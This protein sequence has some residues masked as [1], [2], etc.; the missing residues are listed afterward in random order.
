MSMI[1]ASNYVCATTLENLVL[2]KGA[3][4]PVLDQS[5]NMLAE[6]ERRCGTDVAMLFA[7]PTVKS[8]P[9]STV[10][11]WYAGADGSPRPLADFD[12]IGRRPFAEILRARLARLLPIMAD[13]TIGATVGAA[14]NIRSFQ[15]IYVVGRDAVIVN[16]GMLPRD[17]ASSET[18]REAHFRSTLGS[19]APSGFPTPPFDFK[20]A[21]AFTDAIT[22]QFQA[23]GARETAEARDA[24]QAAAAAQARKAASGPSAPVLRPMATKKHRPWI[25]PLVASVLAAAV[26]VALLMPGV[27][28]NATIISPDQ[29]VIDQQRRLVQDVNRSL[30]QQI[31][32]LKS[33]S[34]E[35]V[36]RAL[37]GA[38]NAA[39]APPNLLPPPAQS[40]R[41]PAS[42]P[43]GP[44][45]AAELADQA[46][47]LV[48]A[49]FGDAGATGSAFFISDQLLV[50]TDHVVSGPGGRDAATVTIENEAL[51]K[52][53]AAKVL[54]RTHVSRPGGADF[55]LLETPANTSRAFLRLAGQPERASSVRSIDFSG[56]VA[57][58]AVIPESVMTDGIV[59]SLIDLN[60]QNVIVNSAATAR[61]SSGGPLMDLCSRAVGVNTLLSIDS[62]AS[63]GFSLAQPTA[64][65]LDFLKANGKNIA[66][67]TTACVPGGI[68]FGGPAATSPASSPASVPGSPPRPRG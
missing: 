14:L 64:A 39:L 7:Q 18:A 52:P 32:E 17:V 48:R 9:G 19:F 25:A 51:G 55:A 34:A 42:I 8:T 56:L 47:V 24:A 61:E 63:A 33:K 6:I 45:N 30:E 29:G 67:D 22:R 57:D 3:A 12:E 40:I 15:D 37:P 54:A 66:L 13:P 28:R 38:S 62:R 16:W 5:V 59:S 11:S 35:L 4:G 60:G 10:V 2:A 1:N 49:R 46:V 43:G 27:L 36:C 31:A 50:T 26:L 65:L 21:G 44:T 68:A 41:V 53:I 23:S 20:D 58:S